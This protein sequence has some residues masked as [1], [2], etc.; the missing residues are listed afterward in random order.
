L[1]SPPPIRV[2]IEDEDK[3]E[4]GD[5]FE[6][7]YKDEYV[8][9]QGTHDMFKEIGT[10]VWFAMR[11]KGFK[12][13][14]NCDTS[15]TRTM[16]NAIH[17][18]T[19]EF[20]TACNLIVLFYILSDY[21]FFKQFLESLS[22][23]QAD[24]NDLPTFD[25]VEHLY[26]TIPGLDDMD[27]NVFLHTYV[28]RSK[29]LSK[30]TN[31]NELKDVTEAIITPSVN[32]PDLGLVVNYSYGL[33]WLGDSQFEL[34]SPHASFGK[35]KW[36]GYAEGNTRFKSISLDT[37]R[38]VFG[39]LRILSLENND[40]VLSV[41]GLNSCADNFVENYIGHQGIS[42]FITDLFTIAQGKYQM[43]NEGTFVLE[44]PDDC[45][46]LFLLNQPKSYV[47]I[48]S[49][50]LGQEM[51]PQY[52][53]D[54]TIIIATRHEPFKTVLFFSFIKD[55]RKFVMIKPENYPCPEY[56]KIGIKNTSPT[57]F[58][59]YTLS[60]FNLQAPKE[61]FIHGYEMVRNKYVSEVDPNWRKEKVNYLPLQLQ[62]KSVFPNKNDVDNRKVYK[63]LGLSHLYSMYPNKKDFWTLYAI[64]K[65]EYDHIEIRTA[66][67]VIITV[68][69]YD[70]LIKLMP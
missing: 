42:E 20:C 19:L 2:V 16:K 40:S 64:D 26:Y 22:L 35:S 66:R 29:I 33:K 63:Q 60:N 27:L 34:Y 38:D 4:D 30:V 58:Y 18:V 39:S 9:V 24:L 70:N 43:F 8:N 11:N 3:N 32:I 61:A 10:S 36:F 56:W 68:N 25:F 55:D 13:I 6:G 41:S 48:S 46:F 31:V 52:G 54:E 67:E 44:D 7:E 65:D 57:R 28:C 17:S 47:R 50:S 1:H 21:N 12:E 51:S 49:H 53:I 59:R 62:P 14:T 37:L 69:E 23:E 5:E 45:V 15:K